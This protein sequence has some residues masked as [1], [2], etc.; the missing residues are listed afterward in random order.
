V[1]VNTPTELEEMW[2]EEV[3]QVDRRS[4]TVGFVLKRKRNLISDKVL[5]ENEKI[6]ETIAVERI[7][8]TR[9]KKTV[10]RKST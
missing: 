8:V 2:L 7:R 3:A 5:D 4:T 10:N 6:F 1:F 9:K